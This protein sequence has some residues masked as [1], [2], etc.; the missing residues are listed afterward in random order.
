MNFAFKLADLPASTDFT[1]LFD[2]Y[3]IAGVAVRII[4]LLGSG[5]NGNPTTT[6]SLWSIPSMVI[7]MAQDLS[8]ITAL[9]NSASGIDSLRQYEGYRVK[10]MNNSN[11]KAISMFIRPK[12]ALATYSG[13]FT[14]YASS[15]A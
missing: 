4:P 8:D 13:A 6:T 9:G 2:R 5:V 10:S 7:H 1:N 12:Q 11:G 15:S 14:S 3:K